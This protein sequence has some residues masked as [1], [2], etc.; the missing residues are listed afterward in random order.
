MLATLT[1]LRIKNLA[2][3]DHLDWQLAPGFT[4][5]TGE[6]GAGKSVIIGA[7]KLLLGERAEKSLIRT[8]SD[9]CTVEARFEVE[10]CEKLDA[11]LDTHG[12]EICDEGNLIIKRSFTQ[13]GSNRQFVNGSP[14]TIAVLKQ[15]GDLLVD[16]HGP[17]DHQSLLSA[18][19]QLDL[20]DAFSHAAGV[21]KSYEETWRKLGALREEHAGLATNE[22][23]LERELELLRHTAEEIQAADL[24]A[25]EEESLQARYALGREQPPPDRAGDRGGARVDR[26]RTLHPEPIGRHRAVAA[27][28]GEDR[29]GDRADGGS[30]H[31][32]GRGTGGVGAR[33]GQLRGE[34]GP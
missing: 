7:L 5:V 23:A 17:H 32:G 11:Q 1:S 4:A 24:R 34:A 12:L 15:L 2:L 31:G 20:L 19:R 33:V 28:V 29:S 6:T 25:D 26:E 3:V 22:A 13:A 14:T 18:E 9:A 8:G 16:L 30:A 21:R 10:D 27:G